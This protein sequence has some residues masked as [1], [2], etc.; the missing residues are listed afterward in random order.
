MKRSAVTAVL[1][2]ICVMSLIFFSSCGKKTRS[3]SFEMNSPTTASVK[4]TT[5]PNTTAAP[6]AAE[7]S[8]EAVS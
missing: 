8:T 2:V 3:Y 5:I 7:E 6:S 4:Y 1:L